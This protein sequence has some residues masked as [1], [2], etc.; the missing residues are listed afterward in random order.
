M[1]LA[2]APDQPDAFEM[3]RATTKAAD[4]DCNRARF[5]DNG[6]N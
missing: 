4:F 1:T 5:R 6:Q 3:R 2:K